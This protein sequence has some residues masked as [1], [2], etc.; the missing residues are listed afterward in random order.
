M[1]TEEYKNIIDE[2]KQEVK[3]HSNPFMQAK[4][5]T[6]ENY[7]EYL[8][9]FKSQNGRDKFR[10]RMKP[11]GLYDHMNET[12]EVVEGNHVVHDELNGIGA[13]AFDDD[14]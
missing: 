11:P 1:S 2:I 7:L 4:C 14:F 13:E 6:V 3:N 8:N 10:G 12:K 5:K 9:N